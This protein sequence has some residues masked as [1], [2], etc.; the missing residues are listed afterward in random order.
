MARWLS[1]FAF[2]A[3]A[4]V[5]ASQGK[6]D[7]SGTWTLDTGKSDDAEEQILATWGDPNR[8]SPK[9]RQIADRLILLASAFDRFEIRQTPRDISLYY[10]DD[11]RIYY[12]DGKKHTRE[13]PWGDKLE[14]VTSWEGN[15]LHLKTDGKDLGDLDEIYTFEGDQ[16]LYTVRLKVKDAKEETVVRSYFDRVKE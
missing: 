6:P 12:I 13:T 5:V 15:E 11:V 7:F 3:L 4:S 8:M 2:L 16:M 14:T 9:D 1:L 10:R